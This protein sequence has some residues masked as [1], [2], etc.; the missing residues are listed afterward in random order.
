M[1]KPPF[2]RRILPW[3]FTIIFFASAPALVFYTAGYRWNPK[4]DKVERNGT[5]IIDSK[6]TG[7]R[8][9]L[10]GND[11]G[12]TTPV[13][14]QNTAPGRYLIRLEK[15][16]YHPWEKRLDVQPEY[17]TFAND[18]WLWKISEPMLVDSGSSTRMEA[19]PNENLLALV[20]IAGKST[21]VRVWDPLNAQSQSFSIP[22]TFHPEFRL[23]WSDDSRSLML[24][25]ASATGTTAWLINVRANTGPVALPNGS[26][27]WN[28]SRLEGSS[29]TANVSINE[30]DGSVTRTPFAPG[31]VDEFDD[32]TIR[33]ATGTDNLVLFKRNDPSRGLILPPGNWHVVTM[34]DAHAI[35]RDGNQWIS[36]DPA[37]ATPNV[38]RAWGDRLR[39]YTEKRK[40]SY[41]L[42]D[43]GEVWMW[44]PAA[45]PEL[46]L[47]QSQTVGE[48]LW[49]SGGRDIALATQKTVSMLNL[50]PRDGRMDT[51]LAAFDAVSD[52]AFEKKTLYVLGDKNGQRGLWSLEIE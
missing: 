3:I 37:A 23:T 42:V 48:A 35:L 31:V 4:K 26:Y 38:I 10:N 46:L 33:H 19:S 1:Y 18:L 49:H 44:N 15:D 8:I 2:H 25:D 17:V 28:G 51:A 22:K 41:V 43:G 6:P 34:N 50:D 45:E 14:L 47:R 5:L 27:E 9:L 21:S 16:G 40:T 7:A 36:V 39:P 13:T 30:N 29:G 11:S 24:E 12:E 20:D 32:L 52:I